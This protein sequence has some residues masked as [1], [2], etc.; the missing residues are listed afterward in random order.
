MEELNARIEL[1][2]SRSGKPVPVVDGIHLHSIYNPE[3]EAQAFAGDYAASIRQKANILVLG[4]GFGYHV[5]EIAKLASAC[6]GDWKILV[7][8]PNKDLIDA[9][10]KSGGFGED[11][12]QIIGAEEPTEVFA[13]EEFIMFLAS[14]PAIIRHD[15]SFNLNKDFFKKFLTFKAPVEMEKYKDIMSEPALRWFGTKKGSLD[16]AL[17]SAGKSGKLADK[18]DYALFVLDAIV[19]SCQNADLKAGRQQT[20]NANS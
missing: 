7:Y 16:Q 3:K 15:A 19:R 10:E 13:R 4:L 8:E 14:K 17:D 18:S 9:F 12:I 6:R 5:K 2:E 20:Q 11:N 1:K